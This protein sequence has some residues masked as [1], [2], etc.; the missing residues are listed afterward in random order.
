VRAERRLGELLRARPETRA[1]D[2][3]KSEDFKIP[4]TRLLILSPLL[5]KDWE[6]HRWE[7]G[8]GEATQIISTLTG[9]SDLI[10][11]PFLGSGTVACYRLS[12]K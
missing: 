1:G 3:H 2:D 8:I 6:F 11:D 10:C 12:Q 7:Q 5:L 9:E 4:P